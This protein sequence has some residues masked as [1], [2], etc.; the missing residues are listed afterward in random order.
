M[1]SKQ[2]ILKQTFNFDVLDRSQ[3]NAF[4]FRNVNIEQLIDNGQNKSELVK[5][6][7]LHPTLVDLIAEHQFE[8]L[9]FPFHTL[10]MTVS[11]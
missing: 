7:E 2:K 6:F 11:F 8:R 5:M 10:P 3:T 1:Q 9:L 4:S